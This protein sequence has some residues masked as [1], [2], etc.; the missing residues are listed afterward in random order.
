MIIRTGI[1]FY[2]HKVKFIMIG[3]TIFALL[4]DCFEK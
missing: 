1:K 2:P 4:Y 3:E